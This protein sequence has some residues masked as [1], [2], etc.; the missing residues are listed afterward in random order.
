MIREP[1]YLP[2]THD[3]YRRRVYVIRAKPELIAH[4]NVNGAEFDEHEIKALQSPIVVMT[5]EVP[6]KRDLEGWR[7]AIKNKCKEAFFRMNLN[8]SPLLRLGLPEG[9]LTDMDICTAFFDRWWDAEE[10]HDIEIVAGCWKT[11]EC[12]SLPPQADKPSFMN[13]TNYSPRSSSVLAC[14]TI[15]IPAHG[16]AEGSGFW[17]GAIQIPL[18]DPDYLF[19]Q[20]LLKRW[21]YR[22]SL[23]EE[24]V[25]L[26]KEEYKSISMHENHEAAPPVAEG[27]AAF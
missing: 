26:L 10:A 17:D 5:E 8:W 19:W 3:L 24:D 21:P 12:C 9:L 16:Y 20:W 23:C 1:R 18:D 2:E 27:S 7:L 4:L 15:N 11:R 13:S 6:S 22:T 14:G 25:L